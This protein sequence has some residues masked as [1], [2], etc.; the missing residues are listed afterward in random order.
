MRKNRPNQR[1]SQQINGAR[2]G[3]SGTCLTRFIHSS[4]STSQR[5]ASARFAP[6]RN[7]ACALYDDPAA[8]AERDTK[9][10]VISSVFCEK[11]LP[12]P[13]CATPLDNP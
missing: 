1:A 8:R 2:S 7:Q 13:Q 12:A 6:T 10:S 9:R 11:P 4:A 5:L 3:R